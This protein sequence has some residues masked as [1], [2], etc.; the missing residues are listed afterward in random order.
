MMVDLLEQ[1]MAAWMVVQMDGKMVDMS[2][3]KMAEWMV[4]QLDVM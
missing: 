3:Q 1:M 4:D 2:G